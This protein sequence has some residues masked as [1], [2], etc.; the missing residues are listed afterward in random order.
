MRSSIH[1]RCVAMAR[2]ATAFV[3]LAPALA[4]GLPGRA[5]TSSDN[6]PWLTALTSHYVLVD[7]QTGD[8][9]GDGSPETVVCYR[10]SLENSN[11]L[12][13]VAILKAKSG[14]PLQPV[15]HVQLEAAC[16][17]VRING[18]KLGML[19]KGTRDDQK[20]LV[21][22]Y[23]E[24]IKFKGDRGARFSDAAVR[25]KSTLGPSSSP[26]KAFDGDL[27]TSW[28]EGAPGTGIGQ[29]L[30]IRF[31]KPTDVGAI[32]LFPGDGNGKR[33]YADHN[34]I[35]RGSIE[36][37]TEADFG[38]QQAGIDFSSLGIDSIGDRVEFDCENRPEVKYIALH[39][40]GV[41]ELQVR[42]DSV[43]LG[44]K[45]DEAHVA[46][47]EIVP[48]LSLS[49]TFDHGTSLKNVA[50]ETAAPKS[51]P[52]AKAKDESAPKVEASVKA[53]DASG[54]SIITED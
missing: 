2:L 26:E 43:F 7:L 13:G 11:G 46:E 48:M 5:A 4:L 30:T 25:A 41:V 54:R 44:D 1:T 32:S 18:R 38:D 3:L 52:S 28:S 53:L 50:K 36:V 10:E 6:G 9:D 12:S 35:H 47:V 15:F 33:G 24:E 34:R 40:K 14:A 39:K 22:T 8:L 49:E 51:A 37:K 45:K 21:W 23:G 29:T 19:L 17:K 20:Q 27:T 16:E 42:I 31:A